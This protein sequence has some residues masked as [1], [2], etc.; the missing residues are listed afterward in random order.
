MV[1]A[2][3]PQSGLL[4]GHLLTGSPWVGGPAGRG[5]WL[6][7]G[8]VEPPFGMPFLPSP[9]SCIPAYSSP[10]APPLGPVV[11]A[12]GGGALRALHSCPGHVLLGQVGG[13]R[14]GG[15]VSSRKAR[16]GERDQSTPNGH[17]C[18]LNTR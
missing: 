15:L 2:G 13:Q 14:D 6:T 7:P 1:P 16:L 17:L 3:I 4:S 10:K 5:S 18:S 11:T 9:P 12:E 8:R